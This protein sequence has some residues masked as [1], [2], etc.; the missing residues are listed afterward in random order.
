MKGAKFQWER[1]PDLPVGVYNAQAVLLERKV[2]FGGGMQREETLPPYMYTYDVDDNLW[3]L[4]PSPAKRAAL[5]VYRGKVVLAGGM[6]DDDTI[7]NKVWVLQDDNTWNESLPPMPTARYGASGLADENF[8]LVVAGV[9]DHRT[10]NVVEIYDG[11]QWNATSPLPLKCWNLWSTYLN[12]YC[13]LIGGEG[14]DKSVLYSSIQSL[15]NDAT[16]EQ[17]E[18]KKL[19][20]VPYSASCTTTFAGTLLAVGGRKMDRR[21]YKEKTSDIFMY[22]PLTQQWAPMTK[23]PVCMDCTCAVS[24]SPHELMVIGGHGNTCN[25]EYLLRVYKGTL[26]NE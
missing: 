26:I 3:Q 1:C 2:Y 7:T 13:F 18:W 15:I 14:Q 5:A 23:M 22:F 8:L 21:G 4:L 9:A 12:G 25:T 10:L 24:L 19:P 16:K 11:I 17:L 6:I 20:D